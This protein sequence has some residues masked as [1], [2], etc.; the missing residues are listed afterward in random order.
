MG[1]PRGPDGDRVLLCH[2]F[3]DHFLILVL[4]LV[5]LALIKAG[6]VGWYFMH[7]K[8]EKQVGLPADHPGLRHGDLPDAHA[9]PRHG[10]EAGGRR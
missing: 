10:D 8:F 3:K 6:M 4:G 1:G 9:L 2:D 5:V 7:L